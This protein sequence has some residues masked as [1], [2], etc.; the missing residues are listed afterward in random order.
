MIRHAEQPHP[1]GVNRPLCVG[2]EYQEAHL[3][4]VADPVSDAAVSY[5]A[6]KPSAFAEK[7]E[8]FGLRLG[9]HGA[10]IP[11]PA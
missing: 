6:A 1:P 8:T 9:L 4:V 3:P 7:L 10:A 5:S 11:P 2:V